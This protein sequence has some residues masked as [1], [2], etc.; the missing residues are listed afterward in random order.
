MSGLATRGVGVGVRVGDGVVVGVKVT[1][2]WASTVRAANTTKKTATNA[3]KNPSISFRMG[4]NLG[5][6]YY[7]SSPLNSLLF[8][9][10]AKIKIRMSKRPKIDIFVGVVLLDNKDSIYLIRENDKYGISLGRWNLP[11]GSVDNDESLPESAKRETVEETGH[12]AKIT[13]LLGV[14]KC[15]KGGKS[16][17]YAVFKGELIHDGKKAV[18]PGVK[19]GKWFEKETFLKMDLS[20]LVHPDMKIVYKIALE[21]RGLSVK[22]VKYIDYG[23]R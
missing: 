7:I 3:T 2:L 19:E 8:H 4:D 6:H 20:Q 10:Y 21:N 14:Y 16:W 17:I 22:T 15:K 18:D 23:K 5:S 13:T 1:L 11:G 9:A 12:D